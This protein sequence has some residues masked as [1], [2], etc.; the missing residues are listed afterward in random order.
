MIDEKKS[1]S[2]SSPDEAAL[3]AAAAHFG[4]DFIDRLPGGTVVLTDR[5]VDKLINKNIMSEL[6]YEV[7]DVLEF[8]SAR[9][10]MS[11][12]VRDGDGGK[13]RLLTKGADSVMLKLL[14][15]GQEKL[16]AATEQIMEEH[17]NEGLR[18]LVIG[19]RDLAAPTYL[20]WS[21]R[22]RAAL[23]NLSE[24]E[25]KSRDEPNA[26]DALMDEMEKDLT[27]LG[28]T[29]IEDKLQDGVPATIRDLSRAGIGT[30][31]LTGDK[32]ETAINIGFACQ[33]L[34]T[35][36]QLLV[37]NKKSH[38]LAADVQRALA[39]AATAAAAAPT[40]ARRARHR[41]RLL[42]GVLATNPDTHELVG[43]QM[44][45]LQFTAL[46]LRRALPL[47]AEQKAQVCFV[48]YR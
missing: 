28:S 19:A 44:P 37:I 27:L 7:L 25:K 46:C 3:V 10:R 13:L 38:P 23:T 42:G 11:V 36:T 20:E 8:S 15:S 4:L 6:K 45:F 1:L 41:R 18:C 9:R 22:Y 5:K 33:L 17:S 40:A 31:V 24:L 14:G 21:A 26:I 12:V 48:R 34:D 32:E 16:V 39:D 35:A 30:W 47:R 2:A 29:A 43:C